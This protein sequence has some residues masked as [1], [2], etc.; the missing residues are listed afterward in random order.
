[1]KYIILLFFYF[2]SAISLYSRDKNKT[3]QIIIK[4]KEDFT[5][6]SVNEKINKSYF[7]KNILLNRKYSHK[8]YIIKLDKRK[9]YEEIEEIVKELKN[10]L[11]IEDFEPDKIAYPATDPNDS[12][13]YL[14]WHYKSVSSEIAG[15]NLPPTWDITTGSTST[16]VAVIDTGILVHEDLSSSRILPGYDMI[17]D[18]SIANDGDGRDNNPN[19]PGDWCLASEKNNSSSPCYDRSCAPNCVKD[20]YSSWHGLFVS[21][22]IAAD[23]NNNLDL[24]GINWK[25]KILPVRVLGKGGGY[26]TDIADAILWAAGASVSGV[27]LNPNVAR[28]INMSL[29]GSDPCPIDVQSAIDVAVSKGI[30]VVVAAGNEN[31][32]LN[33][34]SYWPANCSNVITVSALDRSANRAS[35]SNYGS[36]VFISAP[37]GDGA[38]PVYSLLNGGT[39]VPLSSAYDTW[40]GYYGTSMA[41]PH[42]S[43]VISL[44]LG[45]KPSLSLNEIKYNLQ[46]TARSFPGGSTCNTSICGAGIVD[47]YNA[48]NNLILQVSSST[49]SSAINNSS[50]NIGLWGKGFLSGASVKLKRTGYPDVNC[51]SVN[52]INLNQINCSMPL[53][54]VSSG[55]WNLTVSNLD[56]SSYTLNNYFNVTSL[57]IDT[58]TPSYGYNDSQVIVNINGNGFIWPLS[59]KLKKTGYSDLECSNYSIVTSTAIVCGLNLRG[60]FSGLRDVYILNGDGRSFSLSDSFNIINASLDITSISP[61][62]GYNDSP[63][64]ISINGKGFVPLSTAK[65]SKAGYPDISCDMNVLSSTYSTCN[66]DLNG[67]WDG[68]RDFTLNSGTNSV[69]KTDYFNILPAT[70]SVKNV[71]PISG[72][73]NNPDIEI[74]ISGSGFKNAISYPKIIKSGYGDLI[75]SQFEVKS[76]TSIVSHFDINNT[77]PSIRDVYV[78][79]GTD[80]AF[81]SQSFAIIDHLSYPEIYDISLKYGF[82]NKDSIIDIYGKNFING[83]S[84]KLEKDNYYVNIGSFE[85]ISSTYISNVYLPL[86]DKSPGLWNIIIT[87][88]NSYSAT[89]S[90]FNLIEVKENVR[91][92]QPIIEKGKSDE[93]M[94]TYKNSKNSRVNIRV[95]DNTGHF[96]RTIY[97]GVSYDELNI[98]KWDGRDENGGKVKNGIYVI[99]IETPEYSEYRRVIVIK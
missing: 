38:N 44:M 79:N 93:V 89:Y 84:I 63:V 68:K 60:A 15:I 59:V 64:S 42:I 66:L 30:A 19:D 77:V 12:Y 13:Y 67:S 3:D 52:V 10:H 61:G 55:T 95:Y 23:T 48:I 40:N 41:T 39:T 58:I 9:S 47:A 81:K 31:F 88:P 99:K 96:I 51:N 7:K 6:S 26:S 5:E 27:P 17:S 11:E 74:L 80:F 33:T 94:I 43:G 97:D 29:G 37:G 53:T 35:S 65:I 72:Y 49:P 75:P 32:N 98:I 46:K 8:K 85:I 70:L 91:I 73:N 76:S 54:D 45:L 18:S 83:L 34:T 92:Y 62:Y 14:Q 57:T 71:F 78:Y 36:S 86:K 82:N 90:G 69:T 28:V 1:M 87:N 56:G 20:D 16:V 22:T 24:A 2:I 4:L 21:G 25:A 50:V